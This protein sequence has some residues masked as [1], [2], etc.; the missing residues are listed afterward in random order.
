[1]FKLNKSM[2]QRLNLSRS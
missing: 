1:M 2:E